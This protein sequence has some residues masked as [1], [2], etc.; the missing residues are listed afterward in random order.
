MDVSKDIDKIIKSCNDLTKQLKIIILESKKLKKK[1]EKIKKKTENTPEMENNLGIKKI[2]GKPIKITP[3]L[4]AFLKLNKQTTKIDINKKIY[5]YIDKHNLL[6]P[7]KKEIIPNDELK[8]LLG[9]EDNIRLGYFNL[10]EYI[11]KHYVNE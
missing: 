11:E 2:I 6:D 9:I 4:N 1:Y 7:L 8:Q 5:N 3:E 10:P